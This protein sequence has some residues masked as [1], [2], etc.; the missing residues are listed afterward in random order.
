M[1]QAI[2]GTGEVPINKADKIPTSHN[3]Y[4]QIN[5]REEIRQ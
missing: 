4:K 3:S 2:T 5:E 1:S